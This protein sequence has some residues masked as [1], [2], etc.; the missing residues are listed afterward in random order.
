MFNIPRRRGV[1][2]DLEI[3]GGLR[4]AQSDELGAST[5]MGRLKLGVMLVREPLYLS[6]M[7]TGE[8]GGVA[9]RGIGAQLQLTHVWSG[10]WAHLG[11]AWSRND[12][13]VVSAAVGWALLGVE[14]QRAL[15]SSDSLGDALF[16]E[17]RLPLGIIY[18]LQTRKPA[19]EV[20]RPVAPGP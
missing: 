8:L 19:L 16:L 9:S 15:T 11:G 3:E 1:S 18:A 4:L 2:W 13:A 10:L 20:V 17:L 5:L 7:A 12:T 14:W 6:L